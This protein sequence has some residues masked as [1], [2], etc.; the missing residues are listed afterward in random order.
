MPA[1]FH[2]VSVFAILI[3]ALAACNRAA[4]SASPPTPVAES[5]TA[6]PK[7][8]EPAPDLRQPLPG[9]IAHALCPNPAPCGDNCSNVPYVENRCWTTAHGPAAANVVISADG[10]PQHSTNMLLCGA[11]PYALCFFSGPPV[12]TGFSNKDN[13][14]L[15]CTIEPGADTAS[16]ACQYYGAGISYVDINA[17]IN[18][19]AYYQTVQQCGHDGSLCA[20]MADCKNIGDPANSI[21]SQ[22]APVC[23]YVRN[24]NAD[25]ADQSLVPGADTISTFSL[26]MASDY[27][28]APTTNCRP[29][30][31]LGCMTAPCAFPDGVTQP[32]DETI[33]QCEC[34]LAEGPFQIGQSGAGISCDIANGSDGARYLWSAARTVKWGDPKAQHGQ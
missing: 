30:P 21:C 3:A 1:A 6:A 11:G 14:A 17:I 2:K 20:N 4:E 15:P 10:N 27:K 33:V 16:C 32:A 12:A 34:P 9:M 13:N 29:G 5:T 7:V 22:E 24:Q 18:Q 23:S 28:M 8:V 26:A 25:N 19:N 31:Y